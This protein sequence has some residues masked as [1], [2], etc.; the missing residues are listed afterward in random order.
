MNNLYNPNAEQRFEFEVEGEDG[1]YKTAHR[2]KPL[3]EERYFDYVK[4]IEISEDQNVVE[5]SVRQAFN[6]LWNDLIIEVENVELEEG[7]ELKT[8]ISPEEKNK[9]IEALLA[10]AVVPPENVK[11][12]R[13]LV[14]SD[15]KTILTEAYF[16]NSVTRQTH[17]L[18]A[19]NEEWKR[20]FIRIRA[21]QI[22]EKKNSGLDGQDKYKFIPQDIAFGELYDSMLLNVSGFEGETVPLRFK[23]TVISS[24][25]APKISKS[26]EKK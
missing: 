11:G 21:S 10:V 22:E 9:A 7:Q 23:T 5:N 19:V 13:K 14:S 3:A 26:K 25:F 1:I 6:D 24:H 12:V 15:Q 4:A 18:K 16:N 17:I 20:R 2:F 8:A